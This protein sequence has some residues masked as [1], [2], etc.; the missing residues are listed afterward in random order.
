MGY[1]REPVWGTAEHQYGVQPRTS[2]GR[3][4]EDFKQFRSYTRCS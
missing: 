1:S 2:M 4:N 3:F